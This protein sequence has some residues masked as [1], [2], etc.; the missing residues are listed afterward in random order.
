[1][2]KRLSIFLFLSLAFG[3]A[4]AAIYKWVD[5]DGN[6]HYGE[7]PPPDCEAQA[8]KPKPGP[9]TEETQKAQERLKRLQE[10]Q[11]QSK[12]FRSKAKEVERLKKKIEQQNIMYSRTQ[13]VKARQNLH[14]LEI[15]R[16]VYHINEEGKRVYLDDN[17]RA[18]E[19]RRLRNEI[20]NYCE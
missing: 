14:A 5:K 18:A 6:I 15:K 1:M 4:I 16:P 7:C 17:E 12:E 8:I 2:L 11:R 3:T 20:D 10:Q 13:C 9:S 19:M